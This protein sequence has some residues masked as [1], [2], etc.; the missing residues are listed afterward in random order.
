M[1]LL[2][3]ISRLVSSAF[4]ADSSLANFESNIQYQLLIVN[5]MKNLSSL[6][7][8]HTYAAKESILQNYLYIPRP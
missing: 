6:L 7:I 2:L 3:A 4:S 5:T 1:N 8:F